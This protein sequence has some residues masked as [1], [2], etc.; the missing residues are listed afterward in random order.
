MCIDLFRYGSRLD[1]P[2]LLE[3]IWFAVDQDDPR[4]LKITEVYDVLL[5]IFQ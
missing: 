3:Q 2:F 5:L 1:V 4:R